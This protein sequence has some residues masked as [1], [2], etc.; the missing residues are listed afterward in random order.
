MRGNTDAI[1]KQVLLK[2][3]LE[4]VWEAIAD[5]KKF[6]RWFGAEFDG[7]FVA[8]AHLVGTMKPTAMDAEVARL[9]EPH[10]GKPFDVWIEVLEP[11]TRL[12]FRWQVA[13]PEPGQDRATI[14]TTL[15]TFE[16]EPADGG[17]RLTIT[18]SGF[19]QLPIEKR[20]EAFKNNEGGWEMQAM[21]ISRYLEQE[22]RT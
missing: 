21:L 17:T 9:Q 4:R 1:V 13:E 2:A 18:E 7:P 14:P 20:A 5:S 3:P 6:G 16:L 19:D 15:C 10:Q 11:R 22:A 8:G 12:A